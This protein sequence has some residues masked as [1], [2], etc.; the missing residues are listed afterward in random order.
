MVREIIWSAKAT[1]RY[2]QIVEFLLDK[3]N[4]TVAENFIKTVEAK[5]ELLKLFP[6]MGPKSWKGRNVRT[7]LLTKHNRL[8][9]ML[10]GDKILLVTIY[11][12]RAANYYR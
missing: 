7:L 1:Q 2:R 8:Y 12:T 5:L 3:W 10:K 9:Y 6:E 4:V 11:D